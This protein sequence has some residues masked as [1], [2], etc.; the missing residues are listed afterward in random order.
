MSAIH[1]E[2]KKAPASIAW[3]AGIAFEIIASCY[4][5]WRYFDV[6]PAGLVPEEDEPV[7]NKSSALLELPLP[8]LL[9]V[10]E[11][12]VPVAGVGLGFVSELEV[13]LPAPDCGGVEV[14]GVGE[15]ATRRGAKPGSRL[16]GSTSR[17]M[18]RRLLSSTTSAAASAA[19]PPSSIPFAVPAWPSEPRAPLLSLSRLIARSPLLS[20]SPP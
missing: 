17:T 20:F 16:L 12:L 3:I 1:P 6:P 13:A 19:A 15:R 2:T 5:R 7:P 8:V 14:F 18:P 10:V 9:G 11:L 4:G